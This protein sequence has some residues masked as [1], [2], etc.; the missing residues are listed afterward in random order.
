MSTT[1]LGLIADRKAVT[2]RC[3]LRNVGSPPSCVRH[4]PGSGLTV[5][6]CITRH[7]PILGLI[8]RTIEK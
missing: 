4:Y 6:F 2:C 8:Q 5:A 1:C 7:L 3:L